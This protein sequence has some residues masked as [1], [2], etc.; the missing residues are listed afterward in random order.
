[1]RWNMMR[2][3]TVCAA[4]A[5]VTGTLATVASAAPRNAGSKM[6]DQGFSFWQRDAVRRYRTY[7][8]PTTVEA[9]PA[10][11]VAQTPAPSASNDTAQAP[12]TGAR[13]FSAEPDQNVDRGTIYYNYRSRSF[14]SRSR[15]DLGAG[16]KSLGTYLP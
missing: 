5:L 9:A 7:S 6:R 12:S 2:L 8:A 13:R 10:P 11:V 14:G 16:R 3:L 1:M 15:G 4:V